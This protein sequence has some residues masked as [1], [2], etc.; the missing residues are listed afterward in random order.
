[1][2]H[3]PDTDPPA[4]DLD[5]VPPT[6]IRRWRDATIRRAVVWALSAAAVPAAVGVGGMLVVA[7]DT[8]HEVERLAGQVGQHEVQLREIDRWR[9]STERLI[10]ERIQRADERAAE[11]QRRLDGI[12]DR[13]ERIEGRLPERRRDR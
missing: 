4:P 7:R 9:A 13:L 6:S 5:D 10:E 3:D 12:D 11:V 2:T 8:A 1:M